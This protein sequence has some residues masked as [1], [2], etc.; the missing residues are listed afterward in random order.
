[1]KTIIL[2]GGYGTRMR[3]HTWSRPKPLLNVADNTVLGQILEQLSD[4]TIAGPVIFVVGY[5]GDQIQAWVHEHYPHLDSHFVIQE[6]PLGQ[7]H[8]VW[9]CRD[10]LEEDD[11]VLLAFGDAIIRVDLEPT[12][13]LMADDPSVDAVFHVEKVEDPRGHGVVVLDEHGN[14]RDF[15]EKP[16]TT[17]HN[18]LATGLNWFRSSAQLLHVVDKVMAEQR[19]SFGEYFMADA[20]EVLL[21]EGA[22]VLTRPVSVWLDTGQPQNM[23][24]ANR[25]LLGSG[26]HSEDAIERSYAEDFTVMPPVY[27][28]PEAQIDRAVI[29]PYVTV[30]AGVVI[31]ESVVRN[32]IIDRG[33]I[34]E[35]CVLDGA[36]IGEEAHVHGRAKGLF[37][38][39]NSSV[40]LD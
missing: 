11:E 34:I 25:R 35:R 28:H 4:V 8:A 36:L 1:M 3:P 13:A 22:R 7:A 23:L 18:L 39:D 2:L 38:G 16:Q 32:S 20:Y 17:E 21:Q 12:Q 30:G 26:H 19:Q 5:K 6:E 29:G 31:R 24:E 9:L 37:V 40:E 10:Y 14:V 27:L 33:A 15:V